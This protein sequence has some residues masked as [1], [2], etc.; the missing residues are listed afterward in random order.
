M[1]PNGRLDAVSDAERDKEVMGMIHSE[2]SE[3]MRT[4]RFGNE[5]PG[6]ARYLNWSRHLTASVDHLRDKGEEFGEEMD[7][8]VEWM[9][10]TSCEVDA[11]KSDGHAE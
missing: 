10:P 9:N 3:L 8:L 1:G 7:M 6:G 4:A 2:A 11:R 5:A